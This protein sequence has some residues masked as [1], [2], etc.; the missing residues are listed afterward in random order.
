MFD[1]SNDKIRFLGGYLFSAY[2]IVS[3]IFLMNMIIAVLSNV[4]SDIIRKL[5]A[6]YNA[7]LAIAYQ[8]MQWD[9]KYGLLIFASPPFNF[10][11]FIFMPVLLLLHQFQDK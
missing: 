5:D 2:V 6:D 1:D 4:Y 11:S 7:N 9:S 8:K 3:S 10:I